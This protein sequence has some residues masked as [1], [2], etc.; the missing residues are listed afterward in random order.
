MTDEWSGGSA[1]MNPLFNLIPIFVALASIALCWWA[2][3]GFK[4]ER[5]VTYPGS[6]QAK[7]LHLV[8]AVILGHQFARFILDYVSWATVFRWNF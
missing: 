3:Q 1:L 4:F 7:V 2:L 5:F 6:P 8:L